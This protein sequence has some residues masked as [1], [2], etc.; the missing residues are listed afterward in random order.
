MIF[1]NNTQLVKEAIIMKKIEKNIN[2]N[3]LEKI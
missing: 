3:D 1:I 2:K